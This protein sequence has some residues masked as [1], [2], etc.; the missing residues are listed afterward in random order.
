M[1][2][3]RKTRS[4][5]RRRRLPRLAS[6]RAAAR[7]GQRRA[8]RRQ[9]LHR[10]QGQYRAA[11]RRIRI[12]RRCATTSASRSMSRSTRST[13]SPARPRR[14]TTSSIR[15]RRPR[16]ASSARSTCWASPSACAPRSSRPRPRR[17]MA[18]RPSIR[19]PRIIAA[20]SIRSARAPATTKA[21][22][23]PRRCSSTITASTSCASASRASST[24]TA[25]ACIPMTGASSRT[26]SSRRCKGEPI[27]LYGD[28]SQT[29]AFCY[30][31]DLI[32][33]FVRLMAAPD[34]VTGPI[35]LGNPVE[36]TVAELARQDHRADRLALEDRAPA[37]AGRR[38][39][40]A[41]PRYQ[42]RQRAC[43]AGSRRV[44]LETGL[45]KTIEYF[46]R[47]LG[48]NAAPAEAR[49]VA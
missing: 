33:G 15:C 44:P 19:R 25:R 8:V 34:D 7:R 31:D 35:N 4:R 37:A 41:L 36:T 16:P 32:E 30:V 12:S 21:S 17:S 3:T 6:V 26:S 14:S 48:S 11:A 38:S 27:T 40:A 1:S 23:A 45:K 39:G 42:P 13:I 47:L 9:L 20:T 10:P 22:A 46:D 28:G 18:I 5:H 49:P 2:S 24:P 43:S 29:R